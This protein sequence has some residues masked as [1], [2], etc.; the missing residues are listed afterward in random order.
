MTRLER[1]GILS[2]I[3][4]TFTI[5][6]AVEGVLI[7]SGFRITRLPAYYG[8]LTIAAVMWVPAL[9]TW[10][11][12]KFVTQ[13]EPATL[14][15][16]FGSWKPYWYTALLVPLCFAIIYGLTWLFG[17][18]KPDWQLTQ[19]LAAMRETAGTALPPTPPTAYILL[20]LFAATFVTAPFINALFGLGEE[21]GWRGFLLPKLLPLGKP[22]A[23]L[24]LGVI[25]GLW[26]LPLITIGF[27]Y[28]GQPVL[29]VLAFMALTTAFGIYLNELTLR[30]RSTI[31]AGWVHGLFNSQKLGIW[32]LIFP[33]VDPLVG[34]YAGI[35]GIVVWLA[36]GLWE[37]RRPQ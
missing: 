7:A 4:V 13:E 20:G 23:Y 32:T 26:H 8:Q 36:L 31:L 5:T 18:G 2:Y 11:T 25:W 14:N 6:Y 15:L 10:L 29:G 12:I 35:V 28:P 30:H 27:T 34:G 33:S 37:T 9:A 22:K 1:K 21:I 16:H 24:L 3:A 19:F 17:L